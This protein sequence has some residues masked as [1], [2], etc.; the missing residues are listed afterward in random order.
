MCPTSPGK[1]DNLDSKKG[2]PYTCYYFKKECE[3]LIRSVVDE[4]NHY[5]SPHKSRLVRGN[6]K[7]NM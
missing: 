3:W 7:I 5:L 4:H 1:E 6:R 2:L